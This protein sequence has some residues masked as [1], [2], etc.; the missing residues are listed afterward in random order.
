MCWNYPGNIL[1][2]AIWRL[3]HIPARQVISRHGCYENDSE[4]YTIQLPKSLMQSV[5]NYRFASLNEQICEAI[6]A[7]I[8]A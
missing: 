7:V 8:I 6:V 4:I 5:Q 2:S 3:I 1:A